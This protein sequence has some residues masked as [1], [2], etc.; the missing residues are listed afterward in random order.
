M[1]CMYYD[2]DPE[3]KPQSD[4]SCPVHS[5]T[6]L[7]H[8]SLNSLQPI[9]FY[10]QQHLQYSGQ[11]DLRRTILRLLLLISSGPEGLNII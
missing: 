7:V 5:Y 8:G 4:L 3:L 1:S 10:P 6:L 11:S 2:L 9:V